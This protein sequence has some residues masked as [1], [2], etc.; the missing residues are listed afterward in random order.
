MINK[1]ILLFCGLMSLAHVAY[2]STAEVFEIRIAGVSSCKGNIMLAVYDNESHFMNIEQA[3]AK[4]AF[5][6]AAA[7]CAPAVYRIAIP[8]GQYAVVAYHDANG[9][10]ILDENGLGVPTE[11]WGVSN[12]ARPFFRAPNFSE[13]AVTYAASRTSITINIQ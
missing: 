9:N 11:T 8:Y 5:N 13:C 10:G 12:N 1:S 2:G 3:V 7:N 4:E 6:L